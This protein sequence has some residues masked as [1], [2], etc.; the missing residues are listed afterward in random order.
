VNTRFTHT[1]YT[2]LNVTPTDDGL[3]MAIHHGT[4]KKTAKTFYHIIII[5]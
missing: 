4:L 5:D 2:K 1:R 3:N